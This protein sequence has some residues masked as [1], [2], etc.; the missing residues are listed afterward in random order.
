MEKKE[1]LDLLAHQVLLDSL[2]LKANR[3]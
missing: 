3:V 1:V 2:V